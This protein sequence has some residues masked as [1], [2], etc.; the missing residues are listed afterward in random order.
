M[1]NRRHRARDRQNVRPVRDRRSARPVRRLSH[2]RRCKIDI[3]LLFAQVVAAKAQL[4]GRA[5][6]LNVVLAVC[7]VVG[8][9][10]T[11]FGYAPLLGR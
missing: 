9:Y 6:F 1:R 8:S 3:T 4:L 5:G 7:V 10:L 11:W 2:P